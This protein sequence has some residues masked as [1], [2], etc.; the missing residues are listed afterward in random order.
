MAGGTETF[1][2]EGITGSFCRPI[3]HTPQANIDA[4]GRSKVYVEWQVPESVGAVTMIYGGK[5]L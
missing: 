5:F 4:S 2:T 3:L 1:Q